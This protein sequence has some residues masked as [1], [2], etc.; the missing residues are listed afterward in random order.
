MSNRLIANFQHAFIWLFYFSRFSIRHFYRQRGFQI[1]AS[2]A[3]VVLLS[4]VPLVTVMFGFL[5]GLPVFENMGDSIQIFI[6]NNFAPAFGDSVQEYLKNFSHKASRL[7]ISGIIILVFFSLMLI[8]TIDNALN[9]IWHVRNRRKPAARF[10]V[11]WTILTLGPLLVGIGLVLTQTLP[12]L[13]FL[14][15]SV[16]FTLLYILVPNCFVARRHALIGGI[17]SAMLFEFAKY[18]FGIYV[19]SIANFEAIYGAIAV[20]PMFL[21]WIYTS[22]VIVILGAH[23]TFCLSAFRLEAERS[24]TRDIDW[25]FTDAYRIIAALWLAQKDGRSLSIP[26]FR[27][28][29]IKI[30]HY[31]INEMMEALQQARWVQ[32]KAE[33]SWFLCRDLATVSLMDL[34]RIIPNRIPLENSQ[35]TTDEQTRKL[36]ELL[37]QQHSNQSEILSVSIIKLLKEP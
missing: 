22:W 23:I 20:I 37:Q 2:L 7:T 10:L 32:G 1:A 33:G 6:F 31:Q 16:A 21:V 34:Y 17:F 25:T 9:I 15:T 28:L 35:P 19:T 3:Y 27:N 30:P 14:T 8:A 29:G 4:L 11:Y 36:N 26:D 18:G 13:P 5:G 24:G 12:V